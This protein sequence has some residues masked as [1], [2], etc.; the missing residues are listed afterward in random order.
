MNQTSED[1]EP[2]KSEDGEPKRRRWS[3]LF[4]SGIPQH[5]HPS[6]VKKHLSQAFVPFNVKR[7]TTSGYGD[8]HSRTRGFA[9]VSVR[10]EDDAALAI[11]ALDGILQIEDTT[12]SVSRTTGRCD[13]LFSNLPY[14]TRGQLKLDETA[15]FSV[16]DSVTADWVAK[17]IFAICSALVPNASDLVVTDATA[18]A[19]GNVMGLCRIFCRINAVEID[20]QRCDDLKYNIS[21]CGFESKVRVEHGNCME[22]VSGLQQDIICLDPPWGGQSYSKKEVMTDILFDNQPLADVCAYVMGFCGILA[23]KLPFNFNLDDLVKKM[24]DIA[25]ISHK[26]VPWPFKMEFGRTVVVVFCRKTDRLPFSLPL[27][28]SV[29]ASIVTWN[30]NLGKQHHPAFY[31]WDKHQWVPLSRWHFKSTK[32]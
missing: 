21:L 3:V 25:V 1:G 4:V 17:C 31:D 27:L 22:L 20:E 5:I 9:H 18:C 2:K 14:A 8:K 32:T 24:V 29:I 23:L 12:L 16:T 7:V 26:E 13:T 11:R 6:V 30:T 28:E 10:Q 15:F 19:G